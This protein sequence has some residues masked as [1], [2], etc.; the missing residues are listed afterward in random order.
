MMMMN[1]SPEEDRR[2]AHEQTRLLRA[3]M[4]KLSIFCTVLIGFLSVCVIYLL[5]LS[6][7]NHLLRE[8]IAAY[9]ITAI[10][11]TVEGKAEETGSI[12]DLL[13]DGESKE[14]DAFFGHWNESLFMVFRPHYSLFLPGP[15]HTN[16]TNPIGLW[17]LT[18]Y[19]MYIVL[20]HPYVPASHVV[21]AYALLL[22]VIQ[23]VR[24]FWGSFFWMRVV[25]TT[26]GRWLK[27]VGFRLALLMFLSSEMI[28]IEHFD[29]A[30][31]NQIA[32]FFLLI[33][34]LGCF[35]SGRSYIS[36]MWSLFVSSAID[37]IPLFKTPFPLFNPWSETALMV[38]IGKFFIASEW[39]LLML[40]LPAVQMN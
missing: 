4:K 40:S 12:G 19:A 14:G 35:L 38:P 2:A 34:I 33:F 18:P 23:I 29:A 9:N 8:R 5:F 36:L 30:T 20:L 39:G 7:D 24:R 17:L 25:E 3:K 15:L 21:L 1:N 28:M 27:G 32:S 13:F 10:N 26:P 11:M 16:G 31:Q 22:I 6:S 37:S